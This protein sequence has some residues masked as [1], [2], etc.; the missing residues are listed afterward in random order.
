M[1]RI[2]IWSCVGVL[3]GVTGVAVARANVLGWRGC[4]GHR[5]GH[6]GAMG[7]VAHELNLSDVQKQGRIRAGNG[8]GQSKR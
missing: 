2:A 4:S 7:C 5:W 3:L 1:K 8:S 6:F